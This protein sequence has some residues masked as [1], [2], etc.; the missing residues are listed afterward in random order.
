MLLEDSRM[1]LEWW[2]E[3]E[4][5]GEVGDGPFGTDDH[6]EDVVQTNHVEKV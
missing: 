2:K 3:S 1:W 4:V 6:V 5:D